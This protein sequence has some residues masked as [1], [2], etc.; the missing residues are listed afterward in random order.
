[1]SGLE[2][3]RRGSV[4][5][6][7]CPVGEVSVGEVSVGD[8]SLGNCQSGN[9]PVG[10]LFCSSFQYGLEDEK[11]LRWRGLEDILKAT[12][13]LSW[14]FYKSHFSEDT[15]PSKHL[16]VFKT[17]WRRFQDMSWRR[18]QHIFSVTIFRLPRR[19]KYVLKASCKYV[20]KTFSIRLGRR[21]IVTLKTSWR[22]PPQ[23]FSV[24]GSPR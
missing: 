11:L 18:L 23:R 21:K 1:M 7:N 13:P 15:I 9:C 19:L 22:H 10:K 20:L 24:T 14:N 5:S 2:S 17:S 4:Q 12:I 8:L 6:G 3:L 16:W